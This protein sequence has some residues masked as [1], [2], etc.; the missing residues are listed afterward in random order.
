MSDQRQTPEEIARRGKALYE[1]RI[2]GQ[3]EHDHQGDVLVID[4]DS[5]DFEVDRDH[6]AAAKRLRARRRDGALYAMRVGSPALARIGARTT[7]RGT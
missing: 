1:Q 3:V 6:L 7:S 2:R 5:G 4:V